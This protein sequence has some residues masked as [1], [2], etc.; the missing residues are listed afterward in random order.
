M[1]LKMKKKY[2]KKLVLYFYN[3]QSLFNNTL[4]MTF[5]CTAF[6]LICCVSSTACP[7][8][9]FPHCIK[10]IIIF[11]KCFLMIKKIKFCYKYFYNIKKNILKD[12]FENI[13]YKI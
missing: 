6:Q 2:C 11:L 10:K 8:T 3:A 13:F 5:D 4:N 9:V 7:S 12:I 1:R